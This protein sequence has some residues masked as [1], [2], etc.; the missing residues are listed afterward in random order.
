MMTILSEHNNGSKKQTDFLCSMILS[1]SRKVT[2]IYSTYQRVFRRINS[3]SELKEIQSKLLDK[4]L[5]R[6]LEGQQNTLYLTPLGW[7]LAITALTKENFYLYADYLEDAVNSDGGGYARFYAYYFHHEI[8]YFVDG[9]KIEQ[10]VNDNLQLLTQTST[11][12]Y[13][14]LLP[15]DIHTIGDYYLSTWHTLTTTSQNNEFFV[16]LSKELNQQKQV[17]LP[18]SMRQD[19]SLFNKETISFLFKSPINESYLNR[20][21]ELTLNQNTR[22]SLTHLVDLFI[23]KNIQPELADKISTAY[24]DIP[25]VQDNI[26]GASPWLKELHYLDMSES[27][28]V[29]IF[30]DS[31]MWVRSIVTPEGISW[32]RFVLDLLQMCR[33]KNRE[34]HRYFFEGLKANSDVQHIL[35]ISP[36]FALIGMVQNLLTQLIDV[37]AEACH[38]LDKPNPWRLWMHNVESL[39]SPEAAIHQERLM[40]VISDFRILSAKIQKKGKKGWSQG[41]KVEIEKLRSHRYSYS[42]LSESDDLVIAH[43][44]AQSRYFSRAKG[45]ALDKPLLLVLSNCHNIIDDNGQPIM[46]VPESSLLVLGEKEGLLHC[47]RYPSFKQEESVLLTER[48]EGIYTYSSLPPHIENFF[49]LAN[50]IPPV[51]IG[52]ASGLIEL[53]GQEVDWYNQVER[54]GSITQGEWDCEPHLWVKFDSTYVLLSIEHQSADNHIRTLSGQGDKW[55]F[56]HGKT[57]YQRDIVQENEQVKML[58]QQLTLTPPQDNGV[59]RVEQPRLSELILKLEELEGVKLHWHKTSKKVTVLNQDR[60]NM[61][62]SQQGNWFSL[63][64]DVELD[65]GMILDLQKLLEARRTGYIDL[66]DENR[67]I[68]L[69]ESLR[70]QL[71]LLDSVLNDDLQVDARL[72][73]PLQMLIQSMS[74]TSDKG[75]QELEEQ[76]SEPVEVVQEPLS[77]LRDYQLKSVHW[78]IHL[79]SNGFGACLADDMGLG[80]TLQALKVIEHFQDKGPSLVVCPKSVLLNWQHESAKFTKNL[81]VI[82]LESESDRVGALA[83]ATSGQVVLVSY[84]LIPRLSDAL[85]DVNWAMIILDEAQQIKNPAAQRTKVLVNLQA[86]YRL[87]LSGT[88]V[89]NHLVELWSQ[90]SFLNPGL[91][92]SLKQFK[93][94]YAQAAKNDQDMLRLKA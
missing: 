23:L 9:N 47:E 60:V 61:S 16:K 64:A 25:S 44:L 68:V 4:A 7:S 43:C 65:G 42:F 20:R 77:M 29:D 32:G 2:D 66:N 26:L 31:D 94:K 85:Q 84:G 62:I 6:I 71:N 37:D 18:V 55:L 13:Q 87:T 50:H 74:V 39:L 34:E 3:D 75:W 1:E 91:L 24:L 15:R 70:Q 14:P 79:L 54:N 53:M 49:S 57:W 83:K 11:L 93:A 22:L 45:V 58:E 88:P 12:W 35:T 38:Y 89:E 33:V 27:E 10:D 63:S 52:H 92:G 46:I 72:A 30:Y 41:R 19:R 28:L 5:I 80:K 40:W 69:N 48:T 78:A 86:K 90:F 21:S 76:W 17:V 59:Y 8:L 82:D 36:D 81:V 51:P 73:Y 56:G 67:S